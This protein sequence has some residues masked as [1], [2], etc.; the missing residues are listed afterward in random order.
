MFIYIQL[1]ELKIDR[2]R[3]WLEIEVKKLIEL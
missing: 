1:W 3:L 2:S